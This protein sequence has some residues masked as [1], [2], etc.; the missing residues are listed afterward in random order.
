MEHPQ[1]NIITRC[2]R[3]RNLLK[4]KESIFKNDANIIW[5]IIFDATILKDI[6]AELLS[7]VLMIVETKL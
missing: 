2:S 7:E 3:T 6:D 5:W 1:F 4:I